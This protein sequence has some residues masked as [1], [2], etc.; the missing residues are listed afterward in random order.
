[1]ILKSKTAVISRGLFFLML[2]IICGILIS[3]VYSQVTSKTKDAVGT[4]QTRLVINQG[5]AIVDIDILNAELD[6]N[7]RKIKNV[8]DPT[9]AQDA[10]TKNYVDTRAHVPSG[11]ILLFSPGASCPT[12]YTDITATYNNR[13]PLTCNGCGGITT[14]GNVSHS[15]TV[16]SHNHTGATGST[17]ISHS[18]TVS[19]GWGGALH[20]T[21]GHG[22]GTYFC[23][24]GNNPTGVSTASAGPAH[25][26]TISAE[27]PSTNTADHTPQYF[28]VRICQKN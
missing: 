2:C 15:H 4:L 6:M 17:S 7:T 11:A 26:H 22:A 14:G 16:N 24:G 8:A 1:M 12:G 20:G 28:S 10:A 18:H 25:T 9:A 23:F 19:S 21:S 3:F 5:A 13:F 27:S